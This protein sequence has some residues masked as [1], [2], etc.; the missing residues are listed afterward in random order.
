MTDLAPAPLS[1][2]WIQEARER[3]RA[4]F[5]AHPA[6]ALLASHDDADGLSSAA[7]LARALG[8][9]GRD[10]E[11]RLVGRGE[12][13]W[14]ERFAAEMAR[15]APKALIVADL[16]VAGRAPAPGVPTLVVDHHVPTGTPPDAEVISGYGLE[17]TPSTSL[18]AF[19]V[20]QGLLGEAEAEDLLWLAAIGL[21][22]DYG[23]RAPF[24]E[25]ARAKAR[26]TAKRLREAATLVNA[27]RRAAKGDA[28][29]A[30]ALLM[31]AEDPADLLSGRHEGLAAC[32]AA[33]EEVGA[34]LAEARR[35]A[36]RFGAKGS[37]GEGVAIVRVESPCQVHPLVAQSWV[38]RL[39][40]RPVFAANFGFQPGMVHFSGRVGKGGDLIALLA[41][42]RP[43]GADPARYGNGHRQAAGGA[44]P[45][46]AWDAFVE[47]LGFGPEMRASGA[48]LTA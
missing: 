20:A 34:A 28:S 44:L 45:P 3:A 7:I 2:G 40:G 4:F 32:Q 22:G 17:P 8:R 6:A 42:H 16:G 35:A 47:S 5:D 21:I 38:G 15:R 41:L 14:D 37:P 19:W 33:R 36:P 12:N 30:L 25:L 24:E 27:P 9:A 1:P 10:P 13:A 18:L 26:H 29:P 23:E 11:I 31:A 48:P 46:E 39:K 43:P